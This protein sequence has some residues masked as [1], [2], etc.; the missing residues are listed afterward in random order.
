M[1]N[2]TNNN[3]VEFRKFAE[4]TAEAFGGTGDTLYEKIES[5]TFDPKELL[6]EARI[7]CNNVIHS[8]WSE[9]SK[10]DSEK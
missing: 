8:P 3:A 2:L 7:D 5:S 9:N 1:S 10:L 4:A 6:H